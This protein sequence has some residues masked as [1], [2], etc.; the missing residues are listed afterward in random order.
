MRHIVANKDRGK[1]AAALAGIGGKLAIAIDSVSEHRVLRSIRRGL[2]LILPLALAGSFAQL[3]NDLPVRAYQDAML[4]I[5]G[6][7]WKNF[8]TLVWQGTFAILSLAVAATISYSMTESYANGGNENLHPLFGSMVALACYFSAICADDGALSLEMFGSNGLFLAILVAVLSS[9]LFIGLYSF[10]KLRLRIYSDSSD[11]SVAQALYAMFPAIAAIAIFSLSRII[12]EA[13][14]LESANSAIYGFVLRRFGG[15][16]RASLGSALGFVLLTHVMWFF[17][18]HG[19]NVMEPV[20]NSLFAPGAAMNQELVAQGLQ[21]E[22]IYSKEFFDVFMFFGGSGS[23]LCLIIAILMTSKLTNN[24]RQIAGISAVPGL[25]NVNELMVYGLPIMLNLY[26]LLPFIL[27]PC[28]LALMSVAAMRLGLVP[29]ATRSVNWTTPVILSGY[30]ATGSIRGSLLQLFNVALG[31]ACY[32]PFVLQHQKHMGREN[33]RAFKGLAACVLDGARNLMSRSDN[34]GQLAR[35]LAV[36]LGEDLRL[37]AFGRGARAAQAREAAQAGAPG[38]AAQ[39]ARPAGA[40]H[41]RPAAQAQAQA[42][43]NAKAQAQAQAQANAKAQTQ[44]QAQAQADA[45][46]QTQA[47]TQLQ[48]NAQP[49]PQAQARANGGAKRHSPARAN[50]K[51]QPLPQALE[52]RY[53]PQI[54]SDGTLHGVEALLRWVHPQLGMI[55][56]PVAI[57]LAEEC[58]MEVQ[59]SNWTIRTAFRQLREWNE[60]GLHTVLSVNLSPSQIVDDIAESVARELRLSGISPSEVE[61]EITEQLALTPA[62]RG[63]LSRLKSLGVQLSMD[64]FGMG[65]TSLMYLM[66][67]ELNTL[68]L[69]GVLVKDVITSATSRDIIA[70]IVH[71]AKAS[72]IEIIA[73]YV[74]TK[75]QSDALQELG[76]HIYQGFLYSKPLPPDNLLAYAEGIKSAHAG[77]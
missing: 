8:G 70:S 20:M 68:K 2:I 15:S 1:F 3:I 23:T 30:M 14:G 40:A 45:N 53:Q 66:E 9:Q 6:P 55:P 39:A 59:L 19:N 77:A 41:E 22:H 58:G 67:F 34:I 24:T 62:A 31:V 26:F 28:I 46:A 47:Q 27:T 5:F 50:A 51:A 54:K 44:P 57:A 42:Q 17:G 35:S 65:H 32:A 49:Q 75:E 60:S 25:F 74:E 16:G 63:R 69:D 56:P 21:P 76:C 4:R 36:A 38:K 61:F 7:G 13:L 52:L 11:P 43:A 33:Q 37:A 18:I 73:E 72:G 10:G 71:L 64:D 29:L 12:L 48:A